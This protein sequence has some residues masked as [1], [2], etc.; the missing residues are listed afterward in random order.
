MDFEGCSQ[1]LEYDSYLVNVCYYLLVFR[2]REQKVCFCWPSFMMS[3]RKSRNTTGKALGRIWAK[4]DRLSKL[5]TKCFLYGKDR[6]WSP[7]YLYF[8]YHVTEKNSSFAF[9]FL[10]SH[11]SAPT[12]ICFISG[13]FSF[14]V[15]SC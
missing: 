15:F 12:T 2:S 8:L 10:S 11:I 3:G 7:Q 6:T 9:P 5:G 4:T 13:L 1:Y 14:S